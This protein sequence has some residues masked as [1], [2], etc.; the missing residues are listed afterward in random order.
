MEIESQSLRNT[1]E[2]ALVTAKQRAGYIK[3]DKIRIIAQNPDFKH[4]IST[5]TSTDVNMHTLMEHV[6]NIVTSNEDVNISG[7]TFDVQIFKIPR[8]SGRSKI[9]NLAEVS[10]QLTTMTICVVH[11]LW[12]QL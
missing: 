2:K 5:E 10:Q 1:L 6:E 12:S 11:V 9:I 4:P 8:G 3:G 7:T